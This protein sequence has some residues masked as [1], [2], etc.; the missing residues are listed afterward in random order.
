M[1]GLYINKPLAEL[2]YFVN[3]LKDS[4]NDTNRI[5]MVTEG[6]KSLARDTHNALILEEWNHFLQK[7]PNN[8]ELNPIDLWHSSEIGEN[9]S[10]IALSIIQLPSSTA[11]VERSFSIQKYVHSIHRNRLSHTHVKEEMLIK[12]IVRNLWEFPTTAVIN[13]SFCFS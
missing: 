11:S 5:K 10:K 3:N 1:G 12:Y 4:I 13:H 7:P 2:C 9:L 8:I 6:I